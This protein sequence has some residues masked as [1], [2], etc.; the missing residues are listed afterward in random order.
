MKF[1]RSL[2]A[3]CLTALMLCS[4]CF[5]AFAY[6]DVA[7]DNENIKA[8]EFVDRLGIITSTWNGDFKPEQYLTRADAVVAVYK[9]LYKDEIDQSLYETTDLEFVGDGETGDITEGSALKAY[10][11]WAVDNYLVTTNVENSL[12]KPSEPITSDELITLLAKVL[13]LVEDGA[14]Y[15]DDYVD[16][17]GGIETGLEAGDAPVTREQAAVAFTAAIISSEG[18]SGELGVYVDEDG[19]P[20]DSLAAKVFNMSSIDLVIRATSNKKLGYN[21]ENGTLLSNGADVDLGDDLSDYIGYG[22]TVTYCD[23]DGS[24]TYTEDEEVLTYSISSTLSVT[25]PLTNVSITSGGAATIE[26][27]I[28]N[29][30]FATST[31]LY[32]NDAPWPVNDEKYDLAKLIGSLK[33]KSTKIVNRPNLTFKCMQAEGEEVMTTVFANESRPG[34]VLG[35]NNGIYTIYDYYYAG[36]DNEMR[37]YNVSD[38]KFSGTVKVGDFVSF[39]EANGICYLNPGNAV[40]TPLKKKDVAEI[41]IQDGES[42]NVDLVTTVIGI[43][44]EYTFNDDSTHLEHAFLKLGD[45][46]L[47]AKEDL[48]GPKYTFITDGTEDSYVITWEAYQTNY[49]TL[50]IKTVVKDDTNSKYDIVATNIKTNDEVKFSVGF[51]NVN[52]TTALT[53]DDIITYSDDAAD[54]ETT[55]DTPAEGTTENTPATAADTAATVEKTVFVKKT[56][57]KTLAVRYDETARTFTDTASGKVYYANQTFLG[58]RGTGADMADGDVATVTLALDMANT[59]VYYK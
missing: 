35:I 43:S 45:C 41:T 31:Y 17:M 25:V 44:N 53:D 12:F 6:N 34:K 52:S 50:M 21:V 26:S 19:N 1:M 39:Y 30:S 29:M 42:T 28:G 20:I 15:P 46:L 3:L 59:V 5:T 22:I 14:T 9:M 47:V 23:A 18:S 49:A 24:L 10:L 36:T 48:S 32:L 33:G 11:C 13:C 56:E 58:N 4:M 40:V 8:I 16:A 54:E 7:A 27:D 37:N 51:D 2:V 38:C 55:T 57:Q